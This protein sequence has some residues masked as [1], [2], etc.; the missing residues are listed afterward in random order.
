VSFAILRVYDYDHQGFIEFL[1]DLDLLPRVTLIDHRLL[2]DEEKD[3]LL[4]NLDAKVRHR[5]RVSIR[6]IQQSFGITAVYATHDQ[7]E[8]LS[9]ADYVIVM[10]EGRVEQA[11]SRRK[12]IGNRPLTSNSAMFLGQMVES[13]PFGMPGTLRYSNFAERN[14]A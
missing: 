1:Y 12:F 13:M 7:E 2:T 10:N 6:D 11:G 5:L 3:Q 8:A 14:W 9:M 4:S